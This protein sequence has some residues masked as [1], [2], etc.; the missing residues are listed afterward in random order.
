MIPS[1]DL[2]LLD[3]SVLIHIIRGTAFG[4]R[5][6][7]E[8]ALDIRTEKPLVSVVTVGELLAFARKCGW[9][10]RKIERLEELVASIVVADIRP[11]PIL[12]AYAEI[13]AFCQAKGRSLGQNDLWI[14]ATAAATSATLVTTDKDFDPLVGTHIKRVY[15]DPQEAR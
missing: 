5:L 14:A 13:D 6:V 1:G 7:K 12:E 11:R 8:Q 3:T 9:G 4:K 2:I 15:Y 10:T